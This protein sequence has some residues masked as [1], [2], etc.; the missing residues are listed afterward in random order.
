VTQRIIVAYAVIVMGAAIWA[1]K[2]SHHPIVWLILL[3]ASIPL[4][5]AV[6]GAIFGKSGRSE[7]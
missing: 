5:A 4:F 2:F 7:E 3:T 6:A 1:M